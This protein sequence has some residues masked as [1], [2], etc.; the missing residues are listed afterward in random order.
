MWTLSIVPLPNISS[1][2]KALQ[3]YATK[4]RKFL[5]SAKGTT[6]SLEFFRELLQPPRTRI[7]PT[8]TLDEIR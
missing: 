6:V 4:Q 3:S 1:E 5:L 2:T 8:Q 7:D